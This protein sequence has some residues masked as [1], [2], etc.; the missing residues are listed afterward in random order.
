LTDVYYINTQVV[1]LRITRV[2]ELLQEIRMIPLRKEDI[3]MLGL[4]GFGI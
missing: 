1:V 2:E 4:I 3:I